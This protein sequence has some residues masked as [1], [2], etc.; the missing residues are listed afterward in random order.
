VS[1]AI[2]S[3]QAFFACSRAILACSEPLALCASC[4]SCGL[5]LLGLLFSVFGSL[6]GGYRP[7]LLGLHVVETQATLSRMVWARAASISSRQKAN[8]LFALGNVILAVGQVQLPLGSSIR[9]LEISRAC[10]AHVVGAP[11]RPSLTSRVASRASR[12]ADD[13]LGRWWNKRM[14]LGQFFSRSEL[15][16]GAF[17]ST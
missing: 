10:L 5:L 16:L 15:I 9:L 14:V 3:A 13:L 8:L 12:Y 6:L 11:R 1:S 7:A 4:L 2:V 17:N